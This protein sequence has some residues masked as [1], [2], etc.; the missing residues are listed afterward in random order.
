MTIIRDPHAR[1]QR[2]DEK[3]RALLRFL[4]DELYTVP[5][6]AASIM[7]CGERAAR[8]TVAALEKQGLVR[9]HVVR[10]LDGVAPVTLIAITPHG[11]AMAFGAIVESGV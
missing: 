2:A 9:R 4:R 5:S 10:W 8:Q 11:Q 7:G 6:V 3:R 1:M